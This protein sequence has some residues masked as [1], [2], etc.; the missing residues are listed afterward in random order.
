MSEFFEPATL[1][2][3]VIPI[4]AILGAIVYYKV[5]VK[6]NTK[7]AVDAAEVQAIAAMKTTVEAVSKQNELLKETQAIQAK[8]I[9]ELKSKVNT[10]MNIPLQ[11]LADYRIEVDGKLQCLK[12]NSNK[13][14]EIIGGQP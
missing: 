2:S 1:L 8:E 9:S 4:G 11:Q 3:I 7:L 13:I 14:L 10:L 12:D 5:I 6:S